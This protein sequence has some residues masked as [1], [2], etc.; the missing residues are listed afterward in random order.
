VLVVGCAPHSP[1]L[2]A[3]DN[4]GR[5]AFAD[6]YARVVVLCRAAH[7]AARIDD[8]RGWYLTFDPGAVEDCTDAI[9]TKARKPLW[10]A[11]GEFKS[12]RELP[13]PV[14]RE[15]RRR[16]DEGDGEKRPEGGPHSCH[17]RSW[18]AMPDR[19]VGRWAE[20]QRLTHGTAPFSGPESVARPAVLAPQGDGID[21]RSW[22]AAIGSVRGGLRISVVGTTKRENLAIPGFCTFPRSLPGHHHGRIDS[23]GPTSR[24]EA[25]QGA[26]RSALPD[27]PRP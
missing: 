6:E 27:V 23:S 15:G 19:G 2:E 11:R 12:P 8:H 22:P 1:E 4:E 21:P 25:E 13:G 3:V 26:I 14:R 16:R 5:N 18:S 9:F 10:P 17:D 7:T 24:R 20:G